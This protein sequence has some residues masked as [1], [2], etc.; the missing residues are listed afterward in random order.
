M[1]FEERITTY[2]EFDGRT[3]QVAHAL[4]AAG[5]QAG[6]RIAHLGK[7]SD[8]Y[9]ELLLGA[10]KAGV[11]LT[12]INWRLSTREVA[13]ILADSAAKLLFVGPEFADL[14]GRAAAD[15]A[16]SAII[17]TEA[18]LS[19][20]AFTT[21]RD[22]QP[23]HDP[24]VAIS[25]NDPA[26]QLYT[27]GT[28][29][30]PKGAILSHGNFIAL[31]R[32]HSGER[33]EWNRW[34]VDDVALAAMPVFHIGGV[35]WT[36]TA[37]YNGALAVVAREFDANSVLDFIEAWRISKLFLVPAAMQIVVRLPRARSVDYGRLKYILYG[38]S[39][40]PLELLRECMAVFG[41]GFVQLYGMTETAGAVVALG[42]EDH[43]PDGN[44]RMRSA[45]QPLPG[46]DVAIWDAAGH[47]LAPGEAGEIVVRSPSNMLGYWNLPQATV[48]A[49]T[50]DGWL[51]TGD[52]GYIDQDGY[53]FI[54]DRVKDMIISGG[55]NIYPA[56][57]ENAIFGHPD[58]AEV[59]VV[60]APSERWGEEVKAVVVLKPGGRPDAEGIIVWAR[61]RIASYKA[62]KSVEFV[63]ELPR[64][65]AGKVLRRSLR[66]IG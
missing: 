46:V 3:N 15:F 10:A 57:V 11:V 55:E 13:F 19:G 8:L 63:G 17:G 53:V 16:P 60:G 23:D 66:Q 25:P 58:V 2:G 28:T 36:L 41:S 45:G 38:A 39:P 37:F 12:P 9:F 24:R 50:P 14:A 48:A 27:S 21:W 26:V 29:G 52:A 6:D 31:Q 22:A 49:L 47:A 32:A 40:I 44:R 35:G 59:A 33:Y 1:V 43:D 18:A 54:Q 64:N 65:P 51:R 62:P 20:G 4:R 30:D 34:G 56:E 5:L 7:N 61:A 42:P